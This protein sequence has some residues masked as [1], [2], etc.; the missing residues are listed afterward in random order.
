VVTA[1]AAKPGLTGVDVLEG[2]F[3]AWESAHLSSTKAR[4]LQPE[5]PNYITY[6]E[7]KTAKVDDVVLVDLRNQSLPV[8]KSAASGAAKAPKP[9]TDLSVEFPGMALTQS[10]FALPQSRESTGAGASP[11][12]LLVL[13]DN[14]DGT[15]QAM[16]RTL[17]ANGTRRYVI[18][19][20]GE[21][22]LARHGQ[23]GLQRNSPGSSAPR[24]TT[25][26][27]KASAH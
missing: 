8:R 19:A 22:I 1:L 24:L 23:P 18:L 20:G 17:K 2:G 11:P 13:I 5:A 14:G 25:A 9:L 4:G 21:M 6:K 15:A 26:N 3:A 27:T 16:A 12:P 7:L 10:A